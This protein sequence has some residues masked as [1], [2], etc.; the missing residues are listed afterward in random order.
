MKFSC[1]YR[2]AVLSALL[3]ACL[4]AQAQGD[5]DTL[6]RIV[7]QGKNH[8]QIVDRFHYLCFDIGARL[9]SSP[10]LLKAQK[11]AV[12]QFKKFGC[13]NVHLEQWGTFPVGFDRGPNQVARMVEPFE[14]D[15]E[16]T[17]PA[18]SN[19]TNGLV[20]AEVVAVPLTM[21]MLKGHEQEFK[22]RWVLMPPP[23]GTAPV[24]GS[25]G[26][27][28]IRQAAPSG[29][30]PASGRRGQGGGAIGQSS[31]DRDVLD[32][33]DKI[34]IAGRIAG[35]RN[36][37]VVT[38]G[39]RWNSVTFEKHPGTVQVTVRRSDYERLARNLEFKRKVVVEIDAENRWFKGPVPCYNVIADIKGTEKPDEMVIVSGHFDSWNGPGSQGAQDNGVGAMTAMECARILCAAHAKPKR[40]IRI[41]LWSG[42]EQGIFG[43]TNYVKMHKDELDKISAVL[44]DDG[45]G[46]YQGG[47]SVLP[48]MKAMMEEAIQPM[49]KAFQDLPET[50]SV[51]SSTRMPRGGGSDHAPFNAVGVPGFFTK[52]TGKL[53]YTFVHH[54]QHDRFETT[55]PEYLVQ[56]GTNHAVV[57]YNLACAE[58]LLP[59]EPK[60]VN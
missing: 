39:P 30:A 41:I 4:V 47:Y 5:P 45:G 40:T 54:T 36:E 49:A 55:I 26:T 59:R 52:E 60:P 14:S 1:T 32:A 17:T 58:T 8:S 42:E 7:D 9:T 22:G 2:L 43:S 48:Q 3:P 24:P 20:R 31:V 51:L 38:S 12:S 16:F 33:L 50:I 44:V 27:M 25:P 23:G 46:N 19:G 37:L 10:E 15:M 6:S 35:S 53:D 56:S 18:W 34:G 29:G 11:W 57:S 13:T 21:D 28:A